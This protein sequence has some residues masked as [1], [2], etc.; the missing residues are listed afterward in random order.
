MYHLQPAD[1]KTISFVEDP[2]ILGVQAFVGD[3]TSSEGR[4]S[5]EVLQFSEDSLVGDPTIL[6]G[7]SFVGDPTVLGRQPR[8]R[9]YNLQRTEL[10]RRS[11]NLQKTAS[12][13]ILQSSE[14]RTS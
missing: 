10:R 2:T 7:Q 1:S 8:R 5:Q 6:R 9:S 14:D 3:P 13:E 11:Y 12:Q 4:A